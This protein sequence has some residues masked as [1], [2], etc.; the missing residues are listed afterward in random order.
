MLGGSGA[1]M[2]KSI[3]QNRSL[4]HRVSAFDR[5]KEQAVYSRNKKIYKYKKATTNQLLRIREAITDRNRVN[6]TLRM[7][8]LTLITGVVGYFVYKVLT[9][10]VII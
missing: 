2:S 7:M 4:V 5:L 1:G 6:F 3:Q 9:S 10:T 8:L